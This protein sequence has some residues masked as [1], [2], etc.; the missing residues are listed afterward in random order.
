MRAT[1]RA[2]GKG[3]A[4]G[5][6]KNVRTDHATVKRRSLS[7]KNFADCVGAPTCLLPFST[8]GLQVQPLKPGFNSGFASTNPETWRAKCPGRSEGLGML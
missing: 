4:Q 6:Q 1:H 5:K 7:L 3:A 2:S 8:Q